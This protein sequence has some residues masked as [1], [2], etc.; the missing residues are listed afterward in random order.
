MLVEGMLSFSK[1]LFEYIGA[2]LAH[3][4]K[5]I[6]IHFAKKSPGVNGLRD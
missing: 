1:C 4:Q 5:C 2:N 3:C 6:K